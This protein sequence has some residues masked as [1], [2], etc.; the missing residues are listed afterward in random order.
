MIAH[1]TYLKEELLFNLNS[2]LILSLGG[3]IG[4]KN[5][6][7]GHEEKVICPV[8]ESQNCVEVPATPCGNTQSP[9]PSQ[10]EYRVPGL[11]RAH[12]SHLCHCPIVG[13]GL[14]LHSVVAD[15]YVILA[16][17]LGE[18]GESIIAFHLLLIF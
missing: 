7:T 13:G 16:K 18:Q 4:E 6:K 2:K 10:A 15:D 8:I 17:N 1:H 3:N 9:L 5:G 12:L 14:S 11:D